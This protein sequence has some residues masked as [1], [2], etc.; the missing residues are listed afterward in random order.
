M[1]R[2][3][4]CLLAVGGATTTLP[5]Q[6]KVDPARPLTTIAFGSCADQAKPLP[7]YDTIVAAKPDLLLLLGDNIY[8]DLDRGRPVTPEV[9]QEKYD[10]LAGLPAWQRLK[11][12]VPML[13]TWDDH[14]FGKNDGG[15][16]FTI[17]DDSQKL[18]PRLLRHPGRLAAPRPQGCVRRARLRPRGPAGT[19]D[20]ARHAL[21]PQRTED[22]ARAGRSPPTASS[23]NLTSRRPTPPR[24]SSA[25]NSGPGWRSNSRSPLKSACFAPASRC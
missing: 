7:I 19:G 9:I 18:I 13:A 24:C 20:P 11:A 6:P 17:R 25:T 10:L 21:L 3:L 23:A 5:A 4:A 22:R 14:D 1:P 15:A 16:E 12:A 8:A 2:F